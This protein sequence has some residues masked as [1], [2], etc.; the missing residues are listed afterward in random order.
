MD[1]AAMIATA[2]RLRLDAGFTTPPTVDIDSGLGLSG[3]GVEGLE[4]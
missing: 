3:E 4:G 2:G 1:N